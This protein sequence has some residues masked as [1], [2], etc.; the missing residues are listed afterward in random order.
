MARL[1]SV[2]LA[3]EVEP[4]FPDRCV[5]SGQEH[6]GFAT[7]ILGR[8]DVKGVNLLDGWFAV[9]VPCCRA[10]RWSLHA[11]RILNSFWALTLV[12]LGSFLG[13]LLGTHSAFGWMGWAVPSIEWLCTAAFAVTLVISVGLYLWGRRHPA[14]F[15]FEVYEECVDYQFL[16]SDY[17][18][19]F[20]KLNSG[21]PEQKAALVVLSESQAELLE[22]GGKLLLRTGDGQDL[23]LSFKVTLLRGKVAE[24][25]QPLSPTGPA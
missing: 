8:N 21:V 9:R 24:P 17:A 14:W 23:E 11:R 12:A 2:V 10:R 15:T 7:W 6:P 25:N 22:N 4:Q 5:A 1:L 3:K 19:E 18:A 13:V 20:A 16:S